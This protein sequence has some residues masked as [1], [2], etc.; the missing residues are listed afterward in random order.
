MKKLAYLIVVFQIEQLRSY[1]TYIV[2]IEDYQVDGYSYYD[3]NRGDVV[4]FE[5]VEVRA[6]GTEERVQGDEEL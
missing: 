3:D 5:E 1:I 6:A 2:L 4:D